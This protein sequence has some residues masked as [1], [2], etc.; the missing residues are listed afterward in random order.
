MLNRRRRKNDVVS[1][2]NAASNCAEIVVVGTRVRSIV[3]LVDTRRATDVDLSELVF[4]R[5]SN[6]DLAGRGM[7][8]RRRMEKERSG[9]GLGCVVVG[10]RERGMEGDAVAD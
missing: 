2:S 10:E 7:M 8:R 9:S 3:N 4:V 1:N 6:L 5:K